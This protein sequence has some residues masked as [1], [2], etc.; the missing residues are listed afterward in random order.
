MTTSSWCV[1]SVD[2]DLLIGVG[3]VA[4]LRRRVAA[5]L[6]WKRVDT[7]IVAECCMSALRQ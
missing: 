4:R 5:L 2:V 6:R 1:E 7:E 3:C